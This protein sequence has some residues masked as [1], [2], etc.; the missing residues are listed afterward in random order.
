MLL[1]FS[2]V[3]KGAPHCI[4]HRLGVHVIAGALRVRFR[5]WKAAG[6][7]WTLGLRT[8][9]VPL[10]QSWTSGCAGARTR[11]RGWT[12]GRMRDG[13]EDGLRAEASASSASLQNGSAAAAAELPGLAA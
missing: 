8:R 10:A 11:A 7:S 6:A 3:S 13:D 12:A 2:F 9:L 5:L 4:S 1:F